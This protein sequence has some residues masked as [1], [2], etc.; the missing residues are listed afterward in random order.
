MAKWRIKK[1]IFYKHSWYQIECKSIFGW[2][3]DP[4]LTD[5]YT[6]FNTLEEAESTV[7]S[8]KKYGRNSRKNIIKVYK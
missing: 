4:W 3:Y 6:H 7:L 1:V 8:L 5:R 2:W